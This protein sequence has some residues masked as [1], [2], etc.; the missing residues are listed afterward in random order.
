MEAKKIFGA[1]IPRTDM[2]CQAPAERVKNFK[3]VALG[4]TS[5]MAAAEA[6]RCLQCKKPLCR[7][8]C[9]VEVR[10]P[11]FIARVAEGNLTEAYRILRSTNSLPA[12][13]G[14]VCPQ[15]KQCE[16]ACILG[17]KGEPVAI[18]RLERYVADNASAGACDTDMGC[19]APRHDVRVALHR[20]RPLLAHLRGVSCRARG[21]GHGF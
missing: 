1:K 18:G 11:E 13:C 12:V 2:P 14:R 7:S 17:K 3:E 4:Y 9:P 6:S 5:E 15:E 16:G 21:Q 20:F 8:G 19:A 10:I